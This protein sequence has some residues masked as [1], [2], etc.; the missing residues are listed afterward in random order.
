MYTKQI[1]NYY[2]NLWVFHPA[3]CVQT[4]DSCYI[5]LSNSSQALQ[6]QLV[7]LAFVCVTR[8]YVLIFPEFVFILSLNSPSIMFHI[9]VIHQRILFFKFYSHV[10]LKFVLSFPLFAPERQLNIA[11]QIRGLLDVWFH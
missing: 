6:A 8:C 10:Q 3:V 11:H 4:A 1:S 7:V 5:V 2:T 9:A